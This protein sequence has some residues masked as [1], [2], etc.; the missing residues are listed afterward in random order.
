MTLTHVL[1]GAPAATGVLFLVELIVKGTL[2]LSLAALLVLALR[3]A[4]AA[5]RH[6]VWACALIG[7]VAL[8]WMQL[9]LPKWRVTTPLADRIAPGFGLLATTVEPSPE[10]VTFTGQ[11]DPIAAEKPYK[12][13]DRRADKL[14]KTDETDVL[15]TGSATDATPPASGAPAENA[16]AKPAPSGTPI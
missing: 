1:S 5:H 3:R 4:S 11:S 10:L 14:Q 2:V 16:R 8:P 6:L 15:S 9:S 12:L 7:L 13:E